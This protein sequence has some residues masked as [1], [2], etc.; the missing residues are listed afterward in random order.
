M[1]QQKGGLNDYSPSPSRSVADKWAY[2]H[3]TSI[4]AGT[5]RCWHLT[6]IHATSIEVERFDTDTE[7][8]ST[9]HPPIEVEHFDANTERNQASTLNFARIDD[10]Q[11]KKFGD[12]LHTSRVDSSSFSP[13]VGQ[14]GRQKTACRSSAPISV[15][16]L[17][18]PNNRFHVTMRR[19]WQMDNRT[20]AR[21]YL[22]RS[23]WAHRIRYR[24]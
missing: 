20:T 18:A 7:R 12:G 6:Y 2:I 19:E 11:E 4:R 14:T 16:A 10:V 3:A 1:L 8:T 22:N 15:R 23:C 17:S 24:V 9:L 5:S 13:T 21:R